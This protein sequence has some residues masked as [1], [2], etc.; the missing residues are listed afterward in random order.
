M[1][2]AKCNRVLGGAGTSKMFFN[3]RKNNGLLFQ[4]ADSVKGMIVF[5]KCISFVE[6]SGFVT[7]FL[8]HEGTSCNLFTV[9]LLT[10]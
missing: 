9:I 4:M 3:T 1:H 10:E 2:S 6:E 7:V 5:L 8:E